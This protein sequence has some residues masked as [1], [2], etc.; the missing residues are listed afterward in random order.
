MTG[1][2]VPGT[3]SHFRLIQQGTVQSQHPCAKPVLPTQTPLV[4]ALMV[5]RDRIER[6]KLAIRCFQ[7]QSYPQVQL[8]VVDDGVSDELA[9]HIRSLA[10]DRIRMIRLPDRGQTLG[11]LR[12]LAVAES[13]GQLICQWD[14][15]DLSDPDRLWSQTGLLLQHDLDACFLERW[16]MLWCDGPRLAVS[17]RR[18]WEGSIVARK[19]AVPKYPKLRQG[20]DSPV[21]DAIVASGAVGLLDLAQLYIYCVHSSNTFDPKHFDS[22]WQAATEHCTDAPAAI[23]R[24]QQR[25]PIHQAVVLG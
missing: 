13:A 19:E 16:T 17:T 22:H 5:T 14:D 2:D 10:D 4:S 11:E 20:E 3:F 18:I 23:T 9:E 6:A 21:V 24:L 15:D 7:H 25:V 1:G 12:N 8:V